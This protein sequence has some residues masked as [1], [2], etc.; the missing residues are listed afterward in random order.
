[1]QEMGRVPQ[2]QITMQQRTSPIVQPLNR[3]DT[4]HKKQCVW[5]GR[6]MVV[7]GSSAVNRATRS[8]FKCP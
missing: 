5:K 2:T 8:K 4:K 7:G 3:L 1:M 6:E